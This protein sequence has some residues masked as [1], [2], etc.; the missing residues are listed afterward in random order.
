MVLQLP[1]INIFT[2]NDIN[3][4]NLMCVL[5]PFQLDKVETFAGFL[6]DHRKFFLMTVNIYH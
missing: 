5:S 2:S 6:K 3:L 1:E 4:E